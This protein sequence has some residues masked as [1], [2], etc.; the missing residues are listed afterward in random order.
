MQNMF[1]NLLKMTYYMMLL[2]VMTEVIIDE[3]KGLSS[4]Q[5]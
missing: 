5:L 2:K 4:L 3:V 1:Q